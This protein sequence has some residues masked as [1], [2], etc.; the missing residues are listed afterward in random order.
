MRSFYHIP[1]DFS[2]LLCPSVANLAVSWYICSMDE[3]QLAKRQKM[4][5]RIKE[6][7]LM[8]VGS[9]G[10]AVKLR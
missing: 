6:F 1:Y 10:I 7:T 4:L 9:D 5:A 8:D 3:K 2:L